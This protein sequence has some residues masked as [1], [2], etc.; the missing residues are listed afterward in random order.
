VSPLLTASQVAELLGVSRDTVDD[1]ARCGR[2]PFVNV[3][4]GRRVTRRFRAEAIEAWAIEAEAQ[5]S[6]R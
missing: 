2:L 4:L 3:G 5:G 6:T 1:L